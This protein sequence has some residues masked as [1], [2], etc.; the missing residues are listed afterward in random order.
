MCHTLMIDRGGDY[1]FR[2]IVLLLSDDICR[3]CEV[4]F[5]NV[6]RPSDLSFL[7]KNPVSGVKTEHSRAAYMSTSQQNTPLN[8]NSLYAFITQTHTQQSIN[9]LKLALHKTSPIVI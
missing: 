9:Y 8:A 3:S 4:I 7:R 6:P 2:R 5:K 1:S